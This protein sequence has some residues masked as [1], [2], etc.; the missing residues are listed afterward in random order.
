MEQW[1]KEAPVRL[2]LTAAQAERLRQEWYYRHA[3]FDPLPGG[4]QAVTLG[5]DNR[6]V[7]FDRLRGLGPGAELLEP[8]AW[9]AAF[10]AELE[11]MA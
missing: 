11:Q 7:V 5:E 10:L 2:R 6:S 1:I 3:R 8:A 4:A 9:R